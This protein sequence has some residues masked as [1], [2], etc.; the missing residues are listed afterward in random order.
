MP[1]PKDPT[2]NTVPEEISDTPVTSPVALER[3]ETP[4]NGY[5]IIRPLVTPQQ[6]KENWDAY[7]A[8]C[9]AILDSSDFFQMAQFTRGKGKVVKVY[10]LKS[11]WRKLATAFNLSS[12][13]YKEERIEYDG[14]FVVKIIVRTTA[15]NGRFTDGTGTCASNERTFAHLEHDVRSQAETRAKNRSISD[16]IGGGE[17]SAEEVMQM[18]QKKKEEC[19]RDHDALAPKTSSTEGINKGRPYVRCT[20]CYWGKWTDTGEVWNSGKKK[21]ETKTQEAEVIEEKA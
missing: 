14:Y 13:I 3:K 5:S 17:V 16:M 12:E 11:A 20:L 7:Q 19:P 2:E 10:K 8:L 6:A 15:P 1:T 21:E 4:D 9:N 18:E